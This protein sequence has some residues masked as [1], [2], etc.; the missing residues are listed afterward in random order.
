MLKSRCGHT[1]FY[2]WIC[3]TY[4]NLLRPTILFSQSQNIELSEKVIKLSGNYKWAE[5][6]SRDRNE[7]IEFARRALIEKISTTITST[8][9]QI[10]RE[11]TESLEESFETTTS[12]FSLLSLNGVDYVTT[13]KR[14]RSY[15]T[16][17]FIS[18]ADLAKSLEIARQTQIENWKKVEGYLRQGVL[19]QRIPDVLEAY[20]QTYTYPGNVFVSVADGDSAMV[21]RLLKSEIDNVIQSAVVMASP[22]SGGVVQEIV[23]VRIQVQVQTE[24]HEPLSTVLIRPK[25]PNYSFQDIVDGK[26]EISLDRLPSK[27]KQDVVFEIRPK[28]RDSELSKNLIEVVPIYEKSLLIDYSEIIEIDIEITELAGEG[29]RFAPKTANL[30]VSGI[31][32]RINEEL[33][34]S[35]P[36][37]SIL[38]SQLSNGDVLTM[39]LNSNAQL[40]KHYVVSNGTL[41][42]YIAPVVN[43]KSV[44]EPSI[45]QTPATGSNTPVDVTPESLTPGNSPVEEKVSTPATPASELSVV[46]TPATALSPSVVD[47]SVPELLIPPVIQDI[48]DI[49]NARL[50][51]MKLRELRS[52]DILMF[53]NENEVVSASQAYVAIIDPRLQIL[54][55]FLSP[56]QSGTRYSLLSKAKITSIS[57]TYKGY[58]A[59]YISVY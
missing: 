51:L 44:S 4:I 36:L 28:S 2:V 6:P 30:S 53:G 56:E 33:T 58:G 24:N 9:Q 12:T 39:R 11:T 16:L 22:A 20:F 3:L 38:K 34:S 26:A 29:F 10:A 19:S 17:A 5:Y 35:R 59:I 15:L 1:I 13:Q 48:S 14:D 23:D 43:E 46:N 55:D 18:N 32:W 25:L 52:R 40:E 42:P 37:F 47:L 41:A 7:S 49:R 57:Q 8:V 21:K 45:V 54:A 50:F 27:F 31:E